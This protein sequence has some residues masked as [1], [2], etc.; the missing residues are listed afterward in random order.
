MEIKGT[1]TQIMPLEAGQT[2]A[3]KDWQKQIFVIQ[4]DGQYPKSVAI[5]VFNKPELI[6]EVGDEVTCHINI[7]SREYNGKWYTNIQAWRV[8]KVSQEPMIQNPTGGGELPF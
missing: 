8:E 2:K 5:G 6:P 4:T 3:G 7:E 1:V